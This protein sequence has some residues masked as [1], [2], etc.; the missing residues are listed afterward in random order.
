MQK[1][2]LQKQAWW[3]E[4]M[5]IKAEKNN[6]EP[7]THKTQRVYQAKTKQRTLW[8]NTM[9]WPTVLQTKL[10]Q[11]TKWAW[12]WTKKFRK[13]KIL[14]Q[15]NLDWK[16]VGTNVLATNKTVLSGK[17]P[18]AFQN[19]QTVDQ[20]EIRTMSQIKKSTVLLRLQALRYKVVPPPFYV[21]L[22]KIHTISISNALGTFQRKY[23]LES[24]GV[25]PVYREC[26]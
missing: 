8:I 5:C 4:M 19:C 11:W 9:F 6:A 12:F 3:M 10:P 15:L 1:A 16:Y 20:P 14:H 13:S 7:F 23:R 2:P 18:H 21:K 26:T 24:G 22:R 17:K 25:F